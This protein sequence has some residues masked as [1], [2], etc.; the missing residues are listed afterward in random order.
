M[1]GSSID[2]KEGHRGSPFE[3]DMSVEELSH[4]RKSP[5]P[6]AYKGAD[7]VDRV[8]S[9]NS[10]DNARLARGERTRYK[11]AEQ[12]NYQ[13]HDD[14]VNPRESLIGFEDKML[15][16]EI[17]KR[18]FFAK[19]PEFRSRQETARNDPNWIPTASEW[20]HMIGEGPWKRAFAALNKAEDATS[21]LGVREATMELDRYFRS[22]PNV[23]Y[24]LEIMPFV[25]SVMRFTYERAMTFKDSLIDEADAPEKESWKFDAQFKKFSNAVE[26]DQTKS[27]EWH[28]A[29][30]A[31]AGG[32]R[33]KRKELRMGTFSHLQPQGE[34]DMP[35]LQYVDFDQIEHVDERKTRRG[36]RD[37]GSERGDHVRSRYRR[38]PLLL[39]DGG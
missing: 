9:V 31:T 4:S 17:E 21:Y 13:D 39:K 16:G 28:A 8:S 14:V 36:E 38:S 18:A 15:T 26:N 6:Y 2:H 20:Y 19:H 37:E 34:F 24:P 23:K 5:D 11:T 22:S 25:E 3:G 1:P 12:S 35:V 32:T 33:T 27:E 30:D 10:R 29:W 7:R